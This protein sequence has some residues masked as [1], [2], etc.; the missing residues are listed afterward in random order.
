MFPK[1]RL[2]PDA[3]TTDES[4]I[5]TSGGALSFWNLL[6]HIVEKYTDRDLAVR[7]SKHFEIDFE[8]NQQSRFMIFNGQKHH[9]DD[10]VLLAQTFIEENYHR[11]LFVGTVGAHVAIGNRNL[12]RRFKRATGNTVAQYIQRVRIEAAKKSFETTQKSVSEVMFSSGYTDSKSFRT[13]FFRLSGMSPSEY[14]KRYR[15]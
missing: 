12:E 3:I 6:L 14:R 2:L 13:A 9:Q 7:L 11:P 4:R 15:S 1:V 5:Y 10:S 8:R